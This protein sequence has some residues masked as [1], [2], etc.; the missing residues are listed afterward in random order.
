MPSIQTLSSTGLNPIQILQ[1]DAQ[2]S[3]KFICDA[4]LKRG[5]T[6]K[7]LSTGKVAVIAAITDKVLGNVTVGNKSVTGYLTVQIKKSAV[8]RMKATAAIAIGAQVDVAGYDSTLG[9]STVTTKVAFAPAGTYAAGDFATLNSNG[10]GIALQTATTAGD[11][12][13]VAVL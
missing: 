7:L 9:L 10:Y 11:I 13:E 5:A 3:L 12:I 6:V 8:I 4:L 2:V 1:D